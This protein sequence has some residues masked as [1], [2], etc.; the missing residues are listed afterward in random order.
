MSNSKKIEQLVNTLKSNK[1]VK[2]GEMRIDKPET[3]QGFAEGLADLN[4][5]AT[6]QGRILH[7]DETVKSAFLNLSTCMFTWRADKY[8]IDSSVQ[9]RS[10]GMVVGGFLLDEWKDKIWF[11]DI[12]EPEEREEIKLCL[13]F[14]WYNGADGQGACLRIKDNTLTDEVWL[15]DMNMEGKVYPMGLNLQQ[16]FDLMIEC[17]GFQGWQDAYF[18]KYSEG[19]KRFEEF[20]PEIFPDADMAALLAKFG[21]D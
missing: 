21:K 20:F 19:R 3:E 5:L 12:G 16:Y 11:D 9:I 7:I 17:R 6:E 18:S 8:K 14:D 1:N 13:P 15:Y 2:I 10:L 4:D